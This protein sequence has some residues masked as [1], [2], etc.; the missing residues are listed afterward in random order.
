MVSF[1]RTQFPISSSSAQPRKGAAI[2]FV[3]WVTSAHHHAK[4]NDKVRPTSRHSN[5]VELI[6]PSVPFEPFGPSDRFGPT[7]RDRLRGAAVA[8]GDQVCESL[9]CT[10]LGSF[11]PSSRVAL[12]RVG[13]RFLRKREI[14]PSR[15][16]QKF[17]FSPPVVKRDRC[18]YEEHHHDNR[19]QHPY[20]LARG[21][22]CS[23]C[24][25]CSRGTGS[26]RR[27]A[28]RRGWYSR[29][30]DRFADRLSRFRRGSG[31]CCRFLRSC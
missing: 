6:E 9:L 27:R 10:S 28:K 12:A 11:T 23:R 26:L 17:S 20:G 16:L 25:R 24:S 22:R 5:L 4:A 7:G 3:K 13:F 19:N 1:R 31:R 29:V 2:W 30:R 18:A 15:L 14:L 21:R 8:A